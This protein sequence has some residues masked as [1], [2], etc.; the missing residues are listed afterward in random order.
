MEGL[1]T[2]LQRLGIE[3]LEKDISGHELDAASGA[4]VGLL[5][6]QGRAEVLGNFSE[7]A[8]LMP[9]PL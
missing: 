7:G 9:K 2:G 1:R 6:L 4:L 3:G 8:I 5:F